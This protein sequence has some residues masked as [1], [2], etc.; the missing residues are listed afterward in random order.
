MDTTTSNQVI[1]N[2][3]LLAEEYR[4]I[5]QYAMRTG[6]VLPSSVHLTEA[7]VDIDTYN[8]LLHSIAPASPKSIKYID[9]NILGLDC[10]LKWYQVPLLRMCMIVTLVALIMLIGVSLSPDVNAENQAGGIL[11]TSGRILLINMI[12]VCSAALLGVMF[13]ILKT[14]NQKVK[15]YT[16]LPVDVIELNITIV[17]GVVSGFVVSELFLYTGATLG[18]EIEMQKMTLALL[19]GFSSD[20]IFSILQGIVN[21]IKMLLSTGSPALLGNS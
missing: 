10:T 5:L 18:N 2:S 21:K 7:K 19:G 15:T 4:A 11:A 1:T 14:I 16:L 9:E 17:I 13:F 8:T 12:F 6:T 20:A 3:Q